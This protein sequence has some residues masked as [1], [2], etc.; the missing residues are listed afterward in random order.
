[1]LPTHT[2]QLHR[3]LARILRPLARLLLRNGIAFGEFSELVKRAYVEAAYEDFRHNR[4]KPTDSKAAVLTGL[5]RK[6]IRRL[7]EAGP[8]VSDHTA[9]SHLNRASRVVSGWVRDPDFQDPE[10]APARLDFKARHGFPEL[11]KR[12][13]GD[14]TPRAVLDELIRVGVVEQSDQLVLRKNAYIPAGDDSEMLAIFGEDVGDLIAVID[15]NLASEREPLFQRTLTYNNVPPEI[16]AQWRALAAS[17]SQELLKTLD[18]WLAPYVREVP[19][20]AVGEKQVRTRVG[21][22]YL[23]DPV[24]KDVVSKAGSSGGKSSQ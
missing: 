24:Q 11:V 22:F 15:H 8:E 23:E 13:S 18:R 7:R 6:E 4:R 3:A 14:M 12:Y 5:T 1:M 9:G 2:N 20:T 10:G 17:K 16:M 21:V 19:R